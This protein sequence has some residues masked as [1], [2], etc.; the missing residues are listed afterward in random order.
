MRI[1]AHLPS[2]FSIGDISTGKPH[3]NKC[4]WDNLPHILSEGEGATCLKLLGSLLLVV[5]AG[6]LKCNHDFCRST[7]GDH[8]PNE[9]V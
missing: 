5:S 8:N 2:F 4:Q 3:Q 7:V 6:V 1:I 9:Y